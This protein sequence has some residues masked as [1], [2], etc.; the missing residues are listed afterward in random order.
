MREYELF[1]GISGLKQLERKRAVKR[2]KKRRWANSWVH[3]VP[4]ISS[5]NQNI[6]WICRLKEKLKGKLE[7]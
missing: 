2:Y 7:L 1:L 6:D 3:S 4:V 5:T